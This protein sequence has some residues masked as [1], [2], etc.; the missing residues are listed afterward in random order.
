[1]RCSREISFTHQG[2]G[3]PSHGLVRPKDYD[4]YRTAAHKRAAHLTYQRAAYRRKGDKSYDPSAEVSAYL[5]GLATLFLNSLTAE[6]QD[7]FRSTGF[8][9]PWR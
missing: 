6:H 7:W 9:L 4:G 8:P 1:M 2:T 3:T 5:L